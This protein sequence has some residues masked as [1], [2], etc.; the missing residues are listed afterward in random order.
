[1]AGNGGRV[2]RRMDR[3]TG[4]EGDRNS[5]VVCMPL[6]GF[7]RV[8]KC[9]EALCIF[10]INPLLRHRWMEQAGKIRNRKYTVFS[11]LTLLSISLRFIC[12]SA[13]STS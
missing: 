11:S 7:S 6:K 8:M 9:S 3:N 4:R 2:K 12:L 10:Y 13:M 1:M 5:F